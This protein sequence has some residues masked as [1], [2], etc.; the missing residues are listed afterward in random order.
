MVFLLMVV[1]L[2]VLLELTMLVAR[3]M[4]I[5]DGLLYFGN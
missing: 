4:V 3:V 1:Q 2:A 5:L